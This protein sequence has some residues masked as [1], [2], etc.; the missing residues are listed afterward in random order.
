MAESQ[1]MTL[2][3]TGDLIKRLPTQVRRMCEEGKLEYYKEGGKYFVSRE[4]VDLV[5]H[6][7]AD[8]PEPANREAD[9]TARRSYG[10]APDDFTPSPE[11]G[12]EP[13]TASGR[14][15][16]EADVART[17]VDPDE[18]EAE[19][20][21]ETDW[22]MAGAPDA[23]DENATAGEEMATRGRADLPVS[24]ETEEDQEPWRHGTHSEER[25]PA[26]SKADADGPSAE[27]S[28]ILADLRAVV[29]QHAADQKAYCDKIAGLVDAL[30]GTLTRHEDRTSELTR[31]ISSLLARYTRG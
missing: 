5:M 19:G 3:E 12:A 2:Q 9:G 17:E 4:S 8:E 21:E 23:D 22:I 27:A 20:Q 25:D 6:P 28:D 16:T 30:E 10:R 7:P 15:E 1:W 18:A 14:D 13:E 24:A 11:S 29:A 26:A 31:E